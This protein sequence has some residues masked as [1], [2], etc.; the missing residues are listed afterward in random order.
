MGIACQAKESLQTSDP[1]GG[2]R[3]AKQYNKESF[4]LL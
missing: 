2:E 1:V 3:P 4:V